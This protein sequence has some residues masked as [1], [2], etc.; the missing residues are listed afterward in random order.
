MNVP[1]FLS[2]RGLAALKAGFNVNIG[3]FIAL[4]PVTSSTQMKSFSEPGK[5]N[6][7]SRELIKSIKCRRLRPYL[8]AS[9]SLSGYGADSL[10]IASPSFMLG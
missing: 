10:Q 9:A 8:P 4:T 6:L 5:T 3:Y 1:V 2:K 7:G